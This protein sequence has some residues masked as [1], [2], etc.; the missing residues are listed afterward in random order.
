MN[1]PKRRRAPVQTTAAD[2]AAAAFSQCGSF[3]V[4]VFQQQDCIR[5]VRVI[6]RSRQRLQNAEVGADQPAFGG[7]RV[8]DG[9]AADIFKTA[10]HCP[11]KT[12]GG[13]RVDGSAAAE[14]V[15]Q[16]NAGIADVAGA[17]KNACLQGGG[18]A[19]A[20]QRFGILSDKV[21]I[22]QRQQIL[23]AETAG[24]GKNRPDFRIG[25]NA[26]GLPPA[27]RACRPCG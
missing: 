20:D 9:A 17:G 14:V 4:D 23:C 11:Q 13:I 25:K 3:F 15:F 1:W 24:S 5:K 6:R 8:D 7:A 12:F 22:E 21:I 27:V 2:E 26:S 19:E 16:Q 10:V 18:V